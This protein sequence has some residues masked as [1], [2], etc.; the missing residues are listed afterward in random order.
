MYT[1]ET[2]IG[3][4]ELRHILP[5]E[6]AALVEPENE[7]YR[8]TVTAPFAFFATG[9]TEAEALSQLDTQ[10]RERLQ[11]GARIV[12]RRLPDATEHPLARFVGDLSDYP[13]RDE[14]EKAMQEYR[15]DA[16]SGH[17]YL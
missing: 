17:N 11:H 16:E 8:A 15:N 14:W 2:T 3:V 1:G 7:V 13:R 9:D 12:Y 6:Y 4:T 5:T 10:I